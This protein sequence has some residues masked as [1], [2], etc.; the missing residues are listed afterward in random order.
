[1]VA[2]SKVPSGLARLF[3]V[4]PKLLSEQDNAFLFCGAA[5]IVVERRKRQRQ[6]KSK[7]E[8]S[9]I[10]DGEAVLVGKGEGLLPGP[11]TGL[12]ISQNP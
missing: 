6:A 5:E 12:A 7:F 10:V 2:K 9:G 11:I 4:L 1:L 8:V 3:S